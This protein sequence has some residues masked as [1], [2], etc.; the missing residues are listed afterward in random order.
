M[1][2]VPVWPSCRDPALPGVSGWESIEHIG[3]MTRSVAA[4]GFARVA[5]ARVESWDHRY[6]VADAS[7]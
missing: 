1:G 3:P 2:R 7:R 4:L 6:D 5:P